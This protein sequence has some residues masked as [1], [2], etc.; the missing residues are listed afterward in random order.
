MCAILNYLGENV[1]NRVFA[2]ENAKI[3]WKTI[4]ENHEDTKD[5]ANE[6]YHFLMI[7]L[8]VSNNLIMKMPKLCTHG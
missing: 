4:S 6:K 2:C 3:L 7:N 8:I 5:V 1:F